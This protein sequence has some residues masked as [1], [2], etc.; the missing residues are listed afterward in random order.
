MPLRTV[1]LNL[2]QSRAP[3]P[4]RSY[5]DR[6]VEFDH[7]ARSRER[8]EYTA[9]VRMPYA[10]VEVE[11][12]R[13][14]LRP[15]LFRACHLDILC[16]YDWPGNIRELQNVI[17]RAV[18]LSRGSILR[19]GRDLLPSTSDEPLAADEPMPRVSSNAR[20]SGHDISSCPSLEQVEKRHILDI[21]TQTEWVIEGQRGAAKILDLHPTLR[22]RMKKL[23]IER[24]SPASSHEMSQPRSQNL[25]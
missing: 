9:Y 21:L 12:V 2:F 3:T 20:I 17:E 4:N 25:A 11:I 14:I 19:L 5:R 23:R 24:S 18:V 1:R 13:S 8:I 15:R 7:V 6:A 22:S 10:N 16:R